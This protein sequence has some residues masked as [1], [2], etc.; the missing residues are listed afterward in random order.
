MDTR[1]RLPVF[2]LSLALLQ[3]TR[4]AVAQAPAE[5][6]AALA[7]AD[8]QSAKVLAKFEVEA[9]R[10]DLRELMLARRDAVR[11]GLDARF[12]EFLAGR[13]TLDIL[14]EFARYW[15]QSEHSLQESPS[16]QIAALERYW[17]ITREI[18]EVNKGR[19][20]AGRIPLKDYAETSYERRTA[21][22]ELIQARSAKDKPLPLAGGT[23][24]V[25]HEYAISS[26][27]AKLLAKAEFEASQADVRELA[28]A[29]L[30]T[31]EVIIRSRVL[32]FLAGRGTLDIMLED[33]LR[34]LR[35]ELAV[36]D[37][38]ADRLAAY[39][40][41]WELVFLID[42][43]QQDRYEASRIPIQDRQQA[44][45]FRLQAE[46][47]LLAALKGGKP[48]GLSQ[49]VLDIFTEGNPPAG[50]RFGE[51][52]AEPRRIARAKLA[53][54]HADPRQLARAKLAAAT[55]ES[56]ARWKEFLAGR[57]TLDIFLG[58]LERRLESE[59]ALADNAP[60]R[61]TAHER[62]WRQLLLVD[63]V[64]RGRFEAGR[65]PIQD[66]AQSQHARLDAQIRL[67]QARK[68]GS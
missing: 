39:E 35:A 37:D 43:V 46:L 2:L 52:Y 45:Y 42:E 47:W 24:L 27:P 4:V 62:H 67:A 68:G 59:L 10:A 8:L 36:R 25:L 16:G 56:D 50:I 66:Y 23:A 1:T 60:D 31:A 54:V 5:A 6:D 44:R 18:E 34:W 32:E 63:E 11:V 48:V 15:L 51:V 14:L 64:N 3:D 38:P 26:V 61:R 41:H 7:S 65:I 19:Y 33:G 28:R 12:K 30:G 17:A 22:I 57:G 13:G 20:W 55:E 9:A 21:E 40:R 58:S 49:R 53:A 29:R